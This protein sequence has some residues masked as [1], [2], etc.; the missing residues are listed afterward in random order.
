MAIIPE[1]DVKEFATEWRSEA[2][3]PFL[4]DV[5]ES[6]EADFCRIEGSTLIPLGQLPQRLNELPRDFPIVVH[7]HHGGRSARAVRYLQEQGFGDVRNLV[8]GIEAWSLGADPAVP[9]Y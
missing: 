5:R 2:R 7:C 6:H 3:R 8:G 4:L 9:R 1:V